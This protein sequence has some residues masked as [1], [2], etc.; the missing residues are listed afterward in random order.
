MSRSASLHSGNSKSHLGSPQ[1]YP[2]GTSKD[3][4]SHQDTAIKLN[5]GVKSVSNELLA[6]PDEAHAEIGTTT[7]RS[8][9]GPASPNPS[10]QN[11]VPADENNTNGFSWRFWNSGLN[12]GSSEKPPTPVQPTSTNEESR[13]E[14]AIKSSEDG[15]QAN[16]FAVEPNDKVKNSISGTNKVPELKATGPDTNP[17]VHVSAINATS[18]G[19]LPA[20][21]LSDE[22]AQPQVDA[23]VLA[24]AQSTQ[25]FSWT[26]TSPF[27]YLAKQDEPAATETM[28]LITKTK[29]SEPGT[30]TNENQTGWFNWLWASK[31][32]EDDEDDEEDDARKEDIKLAKQAIETS[33]DDINYAYRYAV[34]NDA[35]NKLL[36]LAVCGTNTETQPVKFKFKKK[37]LTPNEVHERSLQALAYKKT[38]AERQELDKK[39]NLVLPNIDRNFRTIT[40]TTQLRLVFEEMLLFKHLDCHLYKLRAGQI[41]SIKHKVKKVVIVGVHE[42]LP[43]KLNRGMIGETSGSSLTFVKAATKAMKQWLQHDN[44]DVDGY[45][46]NTIAIEGMGKINDRVE[47]G[48]KLLENWHD[49]LK[50]AD[51]VFWVS[52][53]LGSVVATNLLARFIELVPCKH[54]GFLTMAGLFQGPMAEFKSRLSTR[55]YTATENEVNKEM[56]ELQNPESELSKQLTKSMGTLVRHNV[57]ITFAGSIND[58][59]VPVTSSLGNQYNH[60]NIYRVL[61]IDKQHEIPDFIITLFE[62][63]LIMKNKGS[64]NDHNLLRDLCGRCS[65]SFG[66]GGHGK[67]FNESTIYTMAIKQSL[68]TTDLPL[69][70]HELKIHTE[71][72]NHNL[73]MLPWNIRGLLQDLVRLHNVRNFQ[74][75]NRLQAEFKTWQPS[76]KQW[77]EIKFAFDAFAELSLEE[78]V[79]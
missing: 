70:E 24:N 1:P 42:F 66:S 43:I 57:K 79:V 5:N 25:W 37:P 78:L 50:Q 16:G 26:Y 19:I 74:L 32:V 22:T 71:K 41:R 18:D 13:S 59:F 11:P 61:Y 55:P 30:P 64:F 45:D 52:S 33:A 49:V 48:L 9:G 47:H 62:I 23:D 29:S 76:T 3:G 28:P 14:T 34:Q 51:F 15:I 36:E 72:P 2:Q 40:A 46:I 38:E 21:K 8:S 39:P 73:Y 63:I 75:I 56:T 7:S 77:R 12:A 35:R 20:D 60:A 44:I 58:Q 17:T 31:P 54:V 65:A 68:E 6:K 10:Q 67:I 4:K 53:S 27:S 69:Y